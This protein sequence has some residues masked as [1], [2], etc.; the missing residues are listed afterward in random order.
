VDPELS[1]P[2]RTVFYNKTKNK[3]VIGY[4][5]TDPKHLAIETSDT[6]VAIILYPFVRSRCISGKIL[7]SAASVMEQQRKVGYDWS[8]WCDPL[9]QKQLIA[10]AADCQVEQ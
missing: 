6:V 7:R 10:L 2:S 9:P 1:Q 3:A 4:K 8:R 5:G